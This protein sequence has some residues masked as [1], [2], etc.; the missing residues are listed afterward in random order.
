MTNLTRRADFSLFVLRLEGHS[1]VIYDGE[2]KTWAV[3]NYPRRE[4]ESTMAG[5]IVVNERK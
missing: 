3:L 2:E 4:P 5:L 1:W